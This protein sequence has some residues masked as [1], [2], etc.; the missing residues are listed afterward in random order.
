MCHVVTSDP[1]HVSHFGLSRC[2]HP[3]VT[4]WHSVFPKNQ[5]FDSLKPYIE[6]FWNIGVTFSLG[7]LLHPRDIGW[8]SLPSSFLHS[9]NIFNIILLLHI[10]KSKLD[11]CIEYAFMIT[12]LFFSYFCVNW[13]QIHSTPTKQLHVNNYSITNDSYTY[14][15]FVSFSF[16]SHIY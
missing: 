3:M 11:S 16:T 9:K 8:T 7:C 13:I 1:I 15:A 2:D 14:Y 10:F 6:P 12:L 4:S 5:A